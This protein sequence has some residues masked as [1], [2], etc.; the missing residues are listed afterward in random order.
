MKKL[1]VVS[2]TNIFLDLI[3]ID[4]LSAFFSLEFEFH[5]TDFVIG[6]IKDKDQK[7]KVEK[8]IDD[9]KLIVKQF[10]NTETAELITS[11]SSYSSKISIQDCSVWLYAKKKCARLLTGDLQLRKIVEQEKTVQ[12]S[13]IIYVFDELIKQNIITKMQACKKLTELMI[14][15]SRLPNRTCSERIT[16]WSKNYGSK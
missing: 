4:M 1:Y 9:G 7:K 14:I 6:E 16:L 15:N 10:D 13:G 2:D 8:Y 11:F 5:T 12:V 3:T